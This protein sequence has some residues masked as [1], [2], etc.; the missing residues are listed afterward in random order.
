MR[1]PRLAWIALALTAGTV[2]VYRFLN[3]GGGAPPLI[4]SGNPPLPGGAP[5]APICGAGLACT[6]DGAGERW[7]IADTESNRLQLSIRGANCL[8]WRVWIDGD[9]V[10]WSWQGGTVYQS[11]RRR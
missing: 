11:K 4:E 3:P 2:I 9:Y 8:G 5:V 1:V 6:Y 7:A 10:K